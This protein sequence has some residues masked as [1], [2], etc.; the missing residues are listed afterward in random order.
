MPLVIRVYRLLT[1]RHIALLC[2]FGHANNI[3]YAH[4]NQGM[5]RRFGDFYSCNSL[6]IFYV[7]DEMHL[8]GLTTYKLGVG[9]RGK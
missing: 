2:A 1:T 9:S 8:M 4:F 5:R 3:R 6:S 7:I